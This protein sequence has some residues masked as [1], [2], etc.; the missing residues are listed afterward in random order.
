MQ[1]RRSIAYFNKKLSGATLT[2][3]TY[4]KKLY[5]LIRTLET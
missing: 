2:Y 4:D 1:D 3:S 5:V